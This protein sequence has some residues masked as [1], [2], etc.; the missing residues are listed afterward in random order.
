MGKLDFIFLA[1]FKENEI[2]G[3]LGKLGNFRLFD[4]SEAIAFSKST[5]LCISL[6]LE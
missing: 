6:I 5:L 1:I 2:L 3:N 4:K